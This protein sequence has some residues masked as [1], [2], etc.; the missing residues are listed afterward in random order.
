MGKKKK[1]IRFPRCDSFVL[2]FSVIK[3][4]I[5]ALFTIKYGSVKTTLIDLRSAY[6][7]IFIQDG[8]I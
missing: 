7:S 2:F 6:V 5:I 3:D 8:S 1:F 4:M